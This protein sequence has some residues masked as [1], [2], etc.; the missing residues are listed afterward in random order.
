[1]KLFI[2][3]CLMAVVASKFSEF[4]KKYGKKY[5]DA[6]ESDIA[7]SHYNNNTKFFDKHN[8]LHKAGNVFFA[9]GVN[10][11][12]DQ[13]H[14]LLATV[15]KKCT[16]GPPKNHNSRALPA[17]Q[18]ASSFPAGASSKDWTS[19]MQPVRDQGV[20]SSCWAF[21]AIAT[22]ESLYQRNSHVFTMSPQYLV[23]CDRDASN[24][25]CDY[26]WPEMAMSK[27]FKR[28]L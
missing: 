21:A 20:C 16:S 5:K 23:D 7:E 15:H 4:K 26:G 22:L 19:T 10:E 3:F 18:K 27:R 12:A 24:K 25:G 28:R 1:M 11:F 14:V 17:Q 6:N 9:V 8:A 13:H 2:L